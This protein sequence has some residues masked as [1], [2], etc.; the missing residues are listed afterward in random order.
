MIL[1]LAENP[2]RPSGLSPGFPPVGGPDW[3]PG[4]RVALVAWVPVD[5]P[6]QKGNSKMIVRAG[7]RPFMKGSP[8]E[9]AQ[10]KQ[11]REAL[12]Q[13]VGAAGG[14]PPA[15]SWPLS[16]PVLLDVLCDLPLPELTPETGPVWR[17][18]ALRGDPACGPLREGC[19]D[20]GNLLKMI[21]DAAKAALVVDD[22]QLLGGWRGKRWS[23]SPGWWLRVCVPAECTK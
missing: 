19:P 10:E 11:L 18:R 2:R 12:V 1:P 6:R 16:G 4:W 22:R 8:R 3:L 13:A 9:E 14:W 15:L 17:A 23:L 7:S 21:E 5:R 20:T